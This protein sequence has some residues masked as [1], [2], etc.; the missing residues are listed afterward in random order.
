MTSVTD[1]RTR[2]GRSRGNFFAKQAI[3]EPGTLGIVLH[4]MV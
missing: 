3:P 2:N 1:R 4:A